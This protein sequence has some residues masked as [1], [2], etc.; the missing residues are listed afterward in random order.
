MKIAA[1]QPETM[2]LDRR[3]DNVYCWFRTNAQPLRD[4]GGRVIRWY[5]IATEIEDLKRAE[6]GLRERE[7]S[8]RLIVDTIPGLVSTMN[9][10]SSH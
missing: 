10:E 5:G 8:L 4:P 7:A 6:D 9:A 3:F 2:Q 1:V